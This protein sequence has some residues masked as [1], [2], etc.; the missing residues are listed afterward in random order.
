MCVYIYIYV[1]ICITESLA[2]QLKLIQHCELTILQFK[3]SENIKEL[4]VSFE[5]SLKSE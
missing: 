1:Y 2:V 5:L 4:I 3:K